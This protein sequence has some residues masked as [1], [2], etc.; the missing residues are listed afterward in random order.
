M[1]GSSSRNETD[2]MQ[3]RWLQS[4]KS[5]R[6][7]SNKN[8]RKRPQGLV[9]ERIRDIAHLC[10]PRLAE[11]AARTAESVERQRIRAAELEEQ[12][13]RQ[14]EESQKR[15]DELRQKDLEHRVGCLLTEL[16]ISPNRLCFSG[17]ARVCKG[18]AAFA[19]R[20]GTQG[21]GGAD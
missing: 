11:I 3:R 21:R 16:V 17:T 6:P 20:R 2:N 13:R 15:L 18:C 9:A 1:S 5:C 12:R 7:P 14:R 19:T 8:A 10:C 4:I